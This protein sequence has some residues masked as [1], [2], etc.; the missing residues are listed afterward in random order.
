MGV[1]QNSKAKRCFFYCRSS[2]NSTTGNC[3]ARCDD[4]AAK[5]TRPE[6]GSGGIGQ[7]LGLLMNMNPLARQLDPLRRDL[8]SIL[9]TTKH[10]RRAARIRSGIDV[11]VPINGEEETEGIEV[12]WRA[13]LT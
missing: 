1:F 11:S 5:D 4:G 3:D 10:H 9:K 2:R 7:P 8:C 6:E 13:A 12:W